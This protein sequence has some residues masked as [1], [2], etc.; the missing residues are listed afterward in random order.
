MT[1]LAGLLL[2][3]AL[4]P[5][6][7]GHWLLEPIIR[8]RATS[9]RTRRDDVEDACVFAFIVGCAV[10]AAICWSMAS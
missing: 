9:M 2:G 10:A 4:F 1:A 6:L 7:I 8:R 3:F 5:L